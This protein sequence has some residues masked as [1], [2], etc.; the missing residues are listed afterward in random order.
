MY[1]STCF[2]P[3]LTKESQHIWALSGEVCYCMGTHLHMH[4]S[5]EKCDKSHMQIKRLSTRYILKYF[6]SESY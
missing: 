4:K 2:S 3:H 6:D 5:V 1:I